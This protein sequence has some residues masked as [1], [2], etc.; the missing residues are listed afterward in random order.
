MAVFS[1][2][3][4][5]LRMRSECVVLLAILLFEQSHCLALNDLAEN[6][7]NELS[8]YDQAGPYT[9]P[10]SG[11]ER[12]RKKAEIRDFLW[13]HWHKHQ[14]GRLVATQVSKEG[15][16]SISTLLIEPDKNGIWSLRVTMEWQGDPRNPHM[17]KV[18]YRAY[19]VERISAPSGDESQKEMI[20]DAATLPPAKYR[21]ILKDRQGN[22]RER[23]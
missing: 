18:E 23:L 21:L 7:K 13:T 10:P 3:E 1:T 19:G 2:H 4:V 22:V 16:S 15:V 9:I 5:N 20:P 8:H 11:P 17:P 6:Q 14:R 12:A